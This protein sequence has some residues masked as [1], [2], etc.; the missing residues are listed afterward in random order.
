[1]VLL[2]KVLDRVVSTPHLTRRIWALPAAK[3]TF[4]V[5][6]RGASHAIEYERFLDGRMLLR[7][8]NGQE[9]AELTPRRSAK[10]R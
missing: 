4:Q 3:G 7:A 9:S 10:K 6:S 2:A 8:N 5:K 1:M